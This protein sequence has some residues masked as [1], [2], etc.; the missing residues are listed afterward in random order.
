ML[1]GN[2]SAPQGGGVGVGDSPPT[3]RDDQFFNL[4]KFDEIMLG[5][6]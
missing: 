2:L 6:G 5:L 1:K 4:A 3:S